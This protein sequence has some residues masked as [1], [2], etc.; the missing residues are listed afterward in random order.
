MPALFLGHGSPMNAIEQNAFSDAWIALGKTLPKPQAIL[1]VSAHWFTRGTRVND[2]LSPKMVYDM[3]GFPDALYRVAYPAPGAPEVAREAVR[4]L[5]DRAEI[6]NTWG[7]DHGSW[8]LLLR[9]FPHADIPVFQVSVDATAS[10][11][12]HFALGKAL[13]PLRDQGVLILGSGNVV[14][15]L[16]MVDWDFSGGFDWAQTFD[17]Y[18][19]ENVVS[20]S[21]ENVLQYQRAGSS[22]RFSVPTPD[23]FFPLL[24]VL[25]ASDPSDSLRVLTEACVLGSLSMTGYLFQ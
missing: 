4:L 6:D 20:R 9:L 25:G 10:S 18:I 15:N 19:M 1:C 2:S 8:S 21:F 3:Y 12:E 5:G 22:A 16:R 24:S 23:H 7:L 14:H 11:E 17:A 13:R